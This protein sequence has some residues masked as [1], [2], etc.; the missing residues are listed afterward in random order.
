MLY[1]LQIVMLCI[2]L[3]ICDPVTQWMEC[4]DRKG[5]QLY[6]YFIGSHYGCIVLEVNHQQDATQLRNLLFHL[7]Q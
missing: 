3:Y 2:S 1:P 6:F 5:G 7:C 4:E